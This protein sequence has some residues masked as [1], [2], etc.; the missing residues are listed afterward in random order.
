MTSAEP[1]GSASPGTGRP[2]VL[3]TGRF[4]LPG[5]EAGANYVL[6]LGKAL[7]DRGMEVEFLP[8]SCRPDPDGCHLRVLEGFPFHGVRYD[9]PWRGPVGF[10]R[11]FLGIGDSVLHWLQQRGLSGFTHV[12]T[13]SGSCGYLQRLQRLCRQ[14]GCKL[15][16]IVVEWYDIRNAKMDNVVNDVVYILDSEVQRRWI[17]PRFRNLVCISAFLQEYYAARGC[18]TIRIPPLIDLTEDK[19][20]A[21]APVSPPGEPLVLGFAGGTDRKELL[22]ELLRGWAQLEPTLRA[23]FRLR[24][25][26]ASRAAI[27]ERMGRD[28]GVL[29]A[30]SAQIDFAGRLPHQAALTALAQCDATLMLRRNRRF[31]RAGFSTKFVESLACGVP[32]IGNH[33]G[34]LEDYF[35]P[36]VEGVVVADETADAVSRALREF[37]DLSAEQ[38]LAMRHRARCQAQRAF[39]YRHHGDGLARFV[40]GMN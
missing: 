38:R 5:M 26:G 24:L 35:R 23:R 1:S 27:A 14:A 25:L 10:A 22:P 2:R 4:P 37:A 11:S 29:D 20:P 13:Y 28:T 9:D 12:L 40:T 30:L 21:I 32:V 7:R 6:G 18:H 15:A 19:W 31:A 8:G 34:D 33:T 3:L 17:N 16:N 39:D 36:G